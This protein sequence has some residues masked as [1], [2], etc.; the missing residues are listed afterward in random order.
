[1]NFKRF[2]CCNH[3]DSTHSEEHNYSYSM[4]SIQLY[5]SVVL[6]IK[7]TKIQGNLTLCSSIPTFD[8]FNKMVTKNRAASFKESL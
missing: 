7:D 1:M 2:S 6:N 4:S 3:H 8:V 5:N